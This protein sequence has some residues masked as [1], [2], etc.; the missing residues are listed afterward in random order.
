MG[1]TAVVTTPPRFP[2]GSARDG[3]STPKEEVTAAPPS[4]ARNLAKQKRFVGA[5]LTRAGASSQSSDPL[6]R[7]LGKAPVGCRD[8][9]TGLHG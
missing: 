3:T 6:R 7:P 8:D 4:S 1:W 2:P 5:G 9:K